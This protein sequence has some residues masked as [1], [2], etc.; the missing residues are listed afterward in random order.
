[1]SRNIIYIP[2]IGCFHLLET[3]FY[4]FYKRNSPVLFSLP[5]GDIVAFQIRTV[6][7]DL[8][9]VWNTKDG[10]NQDRTMS[11]YCEQT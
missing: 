10:S 7:E 1:M 8:L 11:T 5:L 6:S 4:F 3:F 9:V 2:I